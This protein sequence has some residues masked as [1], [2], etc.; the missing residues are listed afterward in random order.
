MMQA[1]DARITLADALKRGE[2]DFV[3]LSDEARTV[4]T[5]IGGEAHAL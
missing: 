4:L 3:T 5:R 2:V 1:D